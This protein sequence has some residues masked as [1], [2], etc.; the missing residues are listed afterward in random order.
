MTVK[1]KA[2]KPFAKHVEDEVQYG[3]VFDDVLPEGDTIVSASTSVSTVSGTSSTALSV[4]GAAA[5]AAAFND[6]DGFEVAIGRAVQA[7]VSGGTAGCVY[8][9]RVEAVTSEGEHYGGDFRVSVEG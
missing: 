6:D 7:T 2:P 3:F 5:N 1:T 9:V 8:Q 4:S